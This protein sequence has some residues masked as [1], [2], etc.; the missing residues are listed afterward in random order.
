MAIQLEFADRFGRNNPQAYLRIDRALW[1]RG[2]GLQI[3]AAVF[4]DKACAD[5][6]I[7]APV[8]TIEVTMPFDT[9][10]L[11]GGI[12][13]YIMQADPAVAAGNPVQVG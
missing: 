6:G 3:S 11:V 1:L 2:Q 9:A 10:S 5:D 7:S 13:Q 4:V 12:E 8:H